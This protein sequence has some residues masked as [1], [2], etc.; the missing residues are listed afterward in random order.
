MLGSQMKHKSLLLHPLLL[1]GFVWLGTLGLYG[2]RLSKLLSATNEEI[3][4]AVGFILI[5]YILALGA[6]TLYFYLAPKLGIR[7]KHLLCDADETEEL[8]LLK[9]RLKKWLRLW[10]LFSI[11][12]IIVSG[13]VPLVWL[14]SGSSKTYFDFGIHSLHGLL[15]SMILALGLCYAGIFARYGDRRNL[16]C[17]AGILVWSV[18][19]ITRSMMIVNLLQTGMVTVLY[20]GIPRTFAIKLIAVVLI[21]VIGF[22]ALGDLRS[23]AINFRTLAQ[24]TEA[25][26]E[27][28]PS[29][30][31]WVYIYVT[32]PLN[33]LVYSMSSL[34]PVDNILFPN[35]AAPLFPSLVRSLIYGDSL[36]TSLSGELADS[37]FNVSTAYVGPYQDYGALGIMCFSFMISVLA[38]FYW[39]RTNFRDQLIY[40]V[41]G[42]CL[43]MTVFYNHFFS[44]PIITQTGWIYLFFIKGS[45]RKLEPQ[46]S[47][48][49]QGSA[50]I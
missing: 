43:L 22:G 32:T 12:E 20:R 13:G 34:R 33:N 46:Q 8:T 36:S 44:L 3:T 14:F 10:M 23:G 29:G 9:R 40:I 6:T 1:F 19:L 11:V 47:E 35:T 39:R 26:P 31:L 21:V 49:G 41:I 5:P 7:R 48:L 38:A 50:K 30:V 37:S 2:L 42:Q 24:P 28:L 25:Y 27:W 4:S 16:L 45:G 15:N 17:F 18:L